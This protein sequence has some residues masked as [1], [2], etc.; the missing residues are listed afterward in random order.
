MKAVIIKTTIHILTDEKTRNKVIVLILSIVAGMLGVM[1]IPFVVL[2]VMGEM[3]PPEIIIDKGV[4]LSG[5]DTDRLTAMESYGQA[6]VYYLSSREL[7]RQIMKAQL[8]YISYFENIEIDTEEY[9]GYFSIEDDAIL[10]DILVLFMGL[11][12]TITNLSEPTVLYNTSIL[13]AICLAVRTVKI[14]L[15]LPH[16]AVMPM[17]QN[18]FQNPNK[19]KS[20][21]KSNRELPIMSDC[22]W[23][24]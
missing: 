3:E 14:P 2:S 24:I 5:L 20:I 17:S 18:G 23:D 9:A 12:S 13:T 15:I 22:C 6:I 1:M 11:K 21:Q 10:I 7:S 8:I 16:G 19:V 4:L